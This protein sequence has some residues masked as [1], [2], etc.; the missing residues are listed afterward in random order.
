MAQRE[1]CSGHLTDRSLIW[2]ATAASSQN[3]I[4]CMFLNLANLN[5]Q[6]WKTH[7]KQLTTFSTHALC[8]VCTVCRVSGYMRASYCVSFHVFLRLN[9][10]TYTKLCQNTDFGKYPRKQSVMSLTKLNQLRKKTDLYHIWSQKN[11]ITHFSW[12]K[13]FCRFK[14][15]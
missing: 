5:V 8:S 9:R 10:Q 14:K 7:S 13:N 11:T 4:I 12:L 6:A 2:S 15:Y 3:V 1:R